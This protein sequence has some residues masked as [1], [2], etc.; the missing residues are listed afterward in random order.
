M[1]GGVV[2]IKLKLADGRA[3]TIGTGS[4]HNFGGVWLLSDAG[5]LRR[6]TPD[7]ARRLAAAL[8]RAAA[9]EERR[10]AKEPRGGQ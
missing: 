9:I 3:V 7:D 1:E 10:L 6:L 2:V 5:L 8:T 4:D